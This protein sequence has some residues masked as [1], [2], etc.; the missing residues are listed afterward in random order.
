TSFP[1]MIFHNNQKFYSHPFSKEAE[2][3]A[4]IQEIKPDLFGKSRIYLE[5]DLLNFQSLA[6][7]FLPAGAALFP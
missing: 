3:E 1:D 6:Y 2:L 5:I 7:S 4:A